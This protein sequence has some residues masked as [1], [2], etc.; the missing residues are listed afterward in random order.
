MKNILTNICQFHI[1]SNMEQQRSFSTA[2]LARILDKNP[3][4]CINW[5]EM[6]IFLADIQPAAGYASRREFSY[7]GVLRAFL[8]VHFQ[9]KYGFRREKIKSIIVLLWDTG[10][11]RNWAENFPEAREVCSLTVDQVKGSLFILNPYEENTLIMDSALSIAETLKAWEK[12]YIS[13]PFTNM[14]DMIAFNL[15]ELKQEVDKKIAQL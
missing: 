11:F 7:A 13:A 2:Q 14:H 1:L 12:G 8:A 10:F 9:N 15:F 6:G 3:R 4:F 5:A